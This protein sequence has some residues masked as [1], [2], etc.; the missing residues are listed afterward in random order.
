MITSQSLFL[1]CTSQEQTSN[2]LMQRV[3]D[4]NEQRM[5]QLTSLLADRDSQLAALRRDASK[6]KLQKTAVESWLED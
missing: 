5:R 4:R 3:V 1:N 6:L 2:Q